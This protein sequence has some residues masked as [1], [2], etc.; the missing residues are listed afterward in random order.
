MYG[1]PYL[2]EQKRK[3]DAKSPVPATLRPSV[4]D[5]IVPAPVEIEEYV[6]LSITR[7]I[8]TR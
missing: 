5:V 7:V 3:P 8:V 1:A 4:A 2:G 6:E